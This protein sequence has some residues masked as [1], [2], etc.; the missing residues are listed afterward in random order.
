[1]DKK[2]LVLA[3]G[4]VLLMALFLW[5]VIKD[6]SS[7]TPFIGVHQWANKSYS[8]QTVNVLNG[9]EFD[10][11]LAN[12]KRIRGFLEVTAAPEAKKEVVRLLNNS[13]KPRVIL[14]RRK[15]DGHW[16]IELLVQ[17]QSEGWQREVNVADWLRANRLAY[18]S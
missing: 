9:H 7:S 17:P 8:V 3:I 6:Q 12:G 1:M 2:T 4:G 16:C 5:V 10:L 15:D 14:K 18:D 11:Q 13:R